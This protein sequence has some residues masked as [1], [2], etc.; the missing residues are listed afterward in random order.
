MRSFEKLTANPEVY[1]TMNGPSEFHVI[2]VLKN[3]N[4][5]ARLGEIRL[6]TLVTSADLTRRR[7]HRRTVHRGIAG[8][9]WVLFEN[10]GT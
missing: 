5:T 7:R 10:S 4:I 2:G 6:P 8:S 1:H 9:E 3:W